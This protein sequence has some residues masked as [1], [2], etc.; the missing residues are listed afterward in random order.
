MARDAS[1]DAPPADATAPI[2]PGPLIT[3]ANEHLTVDIAAQAG[4]RIAQITYRGVEQLIGPDDGAPAMIAWGG[5]PMVP[6][7]GRIRH[8]RFRFDGRDYQLPL[9]LQEHAIHGVAFGLPWQIDAHTDHRAELSLPLPQDARWP[10]GG[11]ARQTIEVKQQRLEMKLSLQAGTQAM[12]AVIG[13]HP[14]FRKPDCIEFTP[15]AYYPRDHEGIATLPLAPPP[16]A[17]WDDCFINETE[18][19]T[20]RADQKLRLTSNCVHWVVYDETQH[21]TCIEPQT[22]PPDAFNLEPRVLLP[23]EMLEAWF[24][25]EWV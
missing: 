19:I 22:G 25:L 6:W 16:P 15:T 24:L 2:V 13:W 23:G 17:P 3:I 10:F 9:N 12:P 7:A 20:H 5:Y 21:A 4:G 1:R 8:G 14:W 11:T 18:V